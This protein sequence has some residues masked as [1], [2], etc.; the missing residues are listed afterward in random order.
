AAFT[1]KI[2]EHYV[3]FKIRH[4]SFDGSPRPTSDSIVYDTIHSLNYAHALY[5]AITVSVNPKI[6]GMFLINGERIQAIRHVITPLI[7]FSYIPDL[8][9]FLPNYQRTAYDSLQKP[10]YL[11]K[12]SKGETLPSNTYPMY[13]GAFPV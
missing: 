4:P 1:E 10:V 7:S 12:L 13:S 6:Y 2:V 11:N 9:K 3:P 8:S 5:P